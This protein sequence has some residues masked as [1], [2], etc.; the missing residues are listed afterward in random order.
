MNNSVGLQAGI[1]TLGSLAYC[2]HS[3]QRA[4]GASSVQRPKQLSSPQAI[5]DSSPVTQGRGQAYELIAFQASCHFSPRLVLLHPSCW[6]PP[7]ACIAAAAGALPWFLSRRVCMVD[8]CMLSL[9][10]SIDDTPP[11]SCRTMILLARGA[12]QLGTVLLDLNEKSFLLIEC[13]D[14]LWRLGYLESNNNGPP[15]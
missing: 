13:R 1:S 5:L 3:H 12:P 2:H 4:L 6:L 15:V 9:P 10:A 11:G 7:E 14:A 8:A